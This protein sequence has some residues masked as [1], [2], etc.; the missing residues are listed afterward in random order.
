V[1]HVPVGAK[2]H[3]LDDLERAVNKPSTQSN[4]MQNVVG[5][6][7]VLLYSGFKVIGVAGAGFLFEYQ[8]RAISKALPLRR[9]PVQTGETLY[10]IGFPMGVGKIDHSRIGDRDLH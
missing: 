8:F 9:T 1:L 2:A 5:L 3:S 7:L 10:A 4:A 6:G